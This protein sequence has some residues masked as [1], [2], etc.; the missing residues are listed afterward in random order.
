MACILAVIPS[1]ST[2]LFFHNPRLEGK[3]ER[4]I[5]FVVL[6]VSTTRGTVEPKYST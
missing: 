4:R 1:T 6:V 2:A 3:R 5:I